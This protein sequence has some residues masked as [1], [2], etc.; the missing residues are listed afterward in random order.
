MGPKKSMWLFRGAAKSYLAS[1]FTLASQ[2]NVDYRIGHILFRKH[3]ESY[4]TIIEQVN[5]R[6]GFK[7]CRSHIKLFVNES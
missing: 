6:F 2:I 7:I 4:K 3:D 5:K 1:N